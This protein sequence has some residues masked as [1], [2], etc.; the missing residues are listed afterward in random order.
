[1]DYLPTVIEDSLHMSCW[2]AS[3]G[4][5]GLPYFR[6]IQEGLLKRYTPKLILFNVEDNMLEMPTEYERAGFLRPFYQDHPEI[7]P[8]I[9]A[10]SPFE[11]WLIQSRLYAFNSSFYY[12]FRPYIFHNLDGE[13]VD[14]GWK[15]RFGLVNPR[16]E[17]EFTIESELA[18]LNPEAVDL[19][20]EFMD[21]FKKAGVQVIIVT[22]PNYNL[23]VVNSSTDQY[24]ANYCRKNQIPLFRYSENMSFITHASWY[25]DRDHFNPEGALLF[26]RKVAHKIKDAFD[27]VQD[28]V[29]VIEYE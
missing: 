3:R 10:I 14:H 8:F 24:V 16:E 23:K 1:M 20:E 27:L 22:P 18:P 28:P 11:K 29:T 6:I 9:D 19:F 26:T 2:N 15:P 17:R 21:R 12:L 4:G 7:R 25:G 5:Q 13:L